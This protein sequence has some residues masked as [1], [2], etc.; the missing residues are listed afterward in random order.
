MSPVSSVSPTHSLDHEA[1]A[2]DCVDDL[3]H[4]L[5]GIRLHHG[6]RPAQVHA[7]SALQHDR[8]RRYVLGL[9]KHT[10]ASESSP[11]VS[12]LHLRSGE[13]ISVLHKLELP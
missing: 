5:V 1:A 6:Q 9:A 2:L 10:E 7:M 13:F 8:L 12:R 4:V 11:F 3:A